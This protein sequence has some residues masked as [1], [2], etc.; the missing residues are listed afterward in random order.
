MSRLS[1]HQLFV[2]RL[3]PDEDLADMV[4][5]AIADDKGRI[6]TRV[7]TNN[8]VWALERWNEAHPECQWR[9]RIEDLFRIAVVDAAGAAITT[10]LT[11]D[12][13]WAVEEWAGDRA[14]DQ[15]DWK[16]ALAA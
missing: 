9:W 13:A 11:N 14:P 3:K 7:K 5:L 15:F 4:T 8:P 16:P 10:I 6:V 1:P 12:P 2:S